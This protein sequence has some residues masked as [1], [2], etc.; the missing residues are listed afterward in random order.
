VRVLLTL[1][2]RI[3][4]T[5]QKFRTGFLF[6]THF[7]AHDS[8]VETTVRLR[9]RTFELAPEPH[10]SDVTITRRTHE[11][12]VKSGLASMMLP[13]QARAA[14][15]DEV[16]LFHTRDYIEGIK[17]YA[18]GGPSQGAWGYVDEDT[19]IKPTSLE[20]AFYAVGG[21]LNAVDAVM[22]G[23]VR[24]CYALLRPPCHH[25]T[26][27][28]GL[29]Y[30]IFNN[31][32]LAA[33]YARRRY[34]LERVMIVDW[35]AHHGN[36]TQDAFYDDPNVLFVSLH[37]QNWYPKDSGNLEE[38]GQGAGA[39][40][41]V[42]IPL[43]PGTGDKGYQMAFEQ[44]V[45]PIGRQFR[46]QLILITAGQDPSWLDPLTQ[47]MMTMNGFRQISRQMVQLAEEVCDGRLV[48]LQAGGYSAP[49]VPF[50]TA[51]AVEP[52]IGVDLGIV[53][54]YDGADELETSATILLK[55][56][57]EALTRA[58]EWHSQWW[59]L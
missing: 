13:L 36:G 43:P 34:G 8:G 29:G 38:I 11:F 21:A 25:A 16:A 31:T 27:N 53:D 37:Q 42:N 48:M 7:L 58:R 24:N 20:A 52:L 4:L 2:E 51:A 5:V 56:T 10:P 49:Y 17:A 50:C 26:R 22:A 12:L 59:K 18:A 33:L 44:L 35:D 46:P 41:T 54:L 3:A 57:Q 45:V 32:A 6:D 40:L 9:D 39:G 28:Q 15:E 14:S 47:L 19:V 23:T 1:A 30:C 55:E